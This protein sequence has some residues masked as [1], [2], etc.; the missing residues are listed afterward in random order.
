MNY[1]AALE[2]FRCTPQQHL[3]ISYVRLADALQPRVT[4]IVPI[5]DKGRIEQGREQHIATLR[6]ALE[7]SEQTQ[8]DPVWIADIGHAES[9]APGLYLV[10]G[11]HRLTAYRQAGRD[12]IPAS[13]LPMDW[14]AAVAVSKLV[15]CTGRSLALHK[16]QCRDAAWQY[17]AI[18]T[19]R[20]AN[21]L[22][23]GESLRS[24]AGRFG[25]SKNT[26]GSMVTYLPRVVPTEF[27]S[28]SIDPGTGWPRWRYVREANSPWQTSLP[29]TEQQQLD[30]DA[31]KVARSIVKLVDGSSP[32]VRARAL[33]MLANDEVNATDQLAS[34]DL[35]AHFSPPPYRPVP[36]GTPAVP[37]Q[38]AHLDN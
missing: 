6:L 5:R 1:D 24:I 31:E 19:Q 2:R 23:K 37:A 9:V 3:L 11:H 4:R 30:R 12:T 27:N 25:I 21:E 16:E 13:I 14:H 32:A 34:V 22:P 7:V 38:P 26:V 10:D 18:L 17:L 28:L 15:N 33:E 8:L 35:L 20:G 36:I 29:S